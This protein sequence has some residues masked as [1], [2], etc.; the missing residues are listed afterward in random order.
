[1]S[2]FLQGLVWQFW[3]V[4]KAILKAWQTF[5]WFNLNYFSVPV[6]LK[7]YFSHWRRYHYA[8]G[9]PFE[10]WKNIEIFVFNMMS[11][12]IGAIL[13][14][15]FIIIGLAIE[16]LIILIGLIV[17]LAW[18]VLPFFLILGLIFGIRLVLL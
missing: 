13:R 1:M 17:F 8:Y 11:R 18:L 15:V 6:L 3:D 7:T 2:I 10:F 14:T 9:K 12:I 16:I 5:L 4:P